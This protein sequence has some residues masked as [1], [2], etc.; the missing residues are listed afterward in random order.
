MDPRHRPKGQGTTPDKNLSYEEQ[1][2]IT[3]L[4]SLAAYYFREGGCEKALA[5]Y[6]KVLEI[7]P[8]DPRAYAAVQKCYAKA[9]DSVKPTRVPAPAPPTTPDTSP[10][11]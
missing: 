5:T 9:R 2:K 4:N 6:Q 10:N 7:D 11:P 8:R 3:E 1:A